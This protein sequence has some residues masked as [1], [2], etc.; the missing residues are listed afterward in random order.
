MHV[1]LRQGYFALKNQA[2]FVHN[3]FEA[4]RATFGQ[5]LKFK[6]YNFRIDLHAPGKVAEAAVDTCDNVLAPDHR[7]KV[8]DTIR[9]DSCAAGCGC[10]SRQ[11]PR[12]TSVT[13]ST[14]GGVKKQ[15][16]TSFRH[17]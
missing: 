16:P 1:Q 15:W 2:A 17:S 8:Q 5:R 12:I 11:N 6:P 9:N 7:G 4:R 14:F 10:D 3:C 13:C